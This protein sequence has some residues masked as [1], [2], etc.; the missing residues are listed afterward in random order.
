V[1][2]TPRSRRLA[3]VLPLPLVLMLASCQTTGG[4][5]RR[6]A[7]R[8]QSSTAV[9]ALIGAAE[10]SKF[11]FENTDPSDPA[12]TATA[13]LSTMPALGF[14]GQY[15]LGGDK[16]EFGFDGGLLFSW[17]SDSETVA[18]GNGTAVV[19]SDRSLLIVDLFFGGYAS[20][21]LSDQFRI[22]GGLGPSL[23]WGEADYDDGLLSENSSAF[24]VG[25]YLRAGGEFRLAD[26]SFIGLGVRWV[27]TTLDFDG[28]IG[29]VEA[30]GIQGF[31]TYTQ[32]F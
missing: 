6:A 9:Q 14:A 31:L 20:M 1:N 13:D 23:M 2:D 19:V 27:D 29:D 28:A 8:P 26:R 5:T 7:A 15:A 17:D 30:E 16:V 24:G 10:F 22:Y 21:I 18:L 3:L 25:Y 4:Q 12:A 11:E 32:G